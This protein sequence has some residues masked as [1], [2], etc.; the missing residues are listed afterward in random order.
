MSNF[1]VGMIIRFFYGLAFGFVGPPVTESIMGSIPKERA[2]V[3]S[4]VNDTTRQVGGALGVAVLGSIF[5]ARYHQVMDGASAL[6]SA[7]RDSARESIGTTL[8]VVRGTKDAGLATRLRDA[9]FDAFHSS[10]RVTYA[11]AVVII[12]AAMYVAWKYLPNEAVEIEHPV[13]TEVDPVT[14]GL[15]VADPR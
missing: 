1:T 15:S 10:M 4:A 5:A 6:P 13:A 9:G 11:I 8:E 14:G 2:G 12:L 7:V 3:G